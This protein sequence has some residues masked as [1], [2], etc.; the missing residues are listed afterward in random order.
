MASFIHFTAFRG[1]LEI[2]IFVC[3]FVIIKYI[4]MTEYILRTP[5]VSLGLLTG[6]DKFGECSIYIRIPFN[7]R[8]LKKSTNIHIK[9]EYWDDKAQRVTDSCPNSKL[10]NTKISLTLEHVRAE[11]YKLELPIKKKTLQEILGIEER[12]QTKIDQAEREDPDFI[13][14]AMK[15]NDLFYNKGKYGYTSWYNKKR[16]I[17]AFEFYL[18]NFTDFERP[19]LSDLKVEMFDGYVTYRLTTKRNT[20]R[21]GINKTLV[22]LY[23]AIDYAVR[24][25]LMDQKTAAPLSNN[26][27]ESRK[28]NYDPDDVAEDKVKYLSPEQIK[29]FYEYC[30]GVKSRNAR[31]VLDMFFFS[32][33]ACGMRLSDVI[34]L[35]WRNIDFEN[36]TIEKVQVKTKKKAEVQIPLNQNAMAILERWKGY[37]LNAKYVFNRLP[38]DFDVTN[39]QKLFMKRN[40]QDKG[41]NRI[42]A[43]VGRNAKLPIKLTMHVARHSFAVMSINSGMSVYMLSKLLGHSSIAATEKTYAKFLKEKVHAD[44]QILD[45]FN[46]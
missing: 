29:S 45:G 46:F 15:V 14:Y 11:V 23:T 39:P 28:T 7:G 36:R 3:N 2:R 21:D 30:Q 32:Y 19:R 5:K 38:E 1:I 40:A 33:F 37:N 13:D 10:I 20:N 22:P 31:I 8:Y 18:K 42:L 35:E 26:Y 25:G 27:V 16:N 34:T 17:I 44:M 12:E 6:P 41:V 9:P 24:N 43:T 4:V